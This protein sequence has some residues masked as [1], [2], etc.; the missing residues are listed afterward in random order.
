[1]PD[2]I[3]EAEQLFEYTRAL[4][5]DFHHHPE[6]GYQ[7][8]RTSGIVAKKL[9]ELGMQ[10]K[11]G[12]GKTGVV[13]L[14]EGN[15][16]GP[17]IMLR[18]DMDALPI[19][20]E[21]EVAYASINPGVMHAC[22]HDAHTAVGLSVAH[23]LAAH[24]D[25]IFGVVKFVFQPAEEG[26]GGAESMIEDKVLEAPKPDFALALHVWNEKPV[27]WLGVSPGY[28][29]A[30]ADIFD[31]R[32]TGKGGHGALPH[33]TTDP[34]FAAA[35]I[36]TTLQSIPS[37]NVPP[38]EAAV[39]SVTSIHGGDT[40]NVI[41]PEVK[42]EGTIRTFKPQVRQQVLKRFQQV[43]AGTGEI[44]GCQVEVNLRVLTP[45]L[46]NDPAVTARLS[47]VARQLLPDFS[48]DSQYHIMVSEDMAYMMQDIPGSYI[49]VGSANP[50]KGLDAPH[51]HPRFDVDE[52]ALPPAVALMAAAT[53]ELLNS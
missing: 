50:A 12:V 7:E 9:G 43:C 41:P 30:A 20:E 53:L 6:L 29:M 16:P 24:R 22:G 34:V 40:F 35:Q 28:I 8:L 15:R 38:L 26:L 47:D 27:G 48:V 5:R 37:R 49:L 31:V 39:I 1:M 10:V 23:I 14:L 25:D 19:K 13:G 32:I 2:F 33:L 51:H 17:V 45:A 44:L 52:D 36:I 42:L 46:Y 3:Y 11:R 21:S 4:R 18:F